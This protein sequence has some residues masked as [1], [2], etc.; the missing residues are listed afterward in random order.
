ML[1]RQILRRISGWVETSLP[2][3]RTFHTDVH[4]RS[5]IRREK[6]TSMRMLGRLVSFHSNNSGWVETS[7]PNIRTFHRDVRLCSTIRGEKWMSMQMLGRLVSF[8]LNNSGWVET[9]LPNIC[10]FCTDVR[11]RSTIRHEK[12]MSIQMLGRLVSFHSNTL[13]YFAEAPMQRNGFYS[14]DTWQ[15]WKAMTGSTN[16]MSHLL[17]QRLPPSPEVLSPFGLSSIDFRLCLR[18]ISW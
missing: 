3:I 5:T 7:L 14:P 1:A 2:N 16:L 17:Q 15:C 10:I 6:W 9:S 13:A 18:S 11:L 4:L 8:H 12:Q